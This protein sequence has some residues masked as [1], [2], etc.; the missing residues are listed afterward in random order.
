V[1]YVE[2]LPR[3]LE[4]INRPTSGD[5]GSRER[6]VAEMR[7]AG[8]D[9]VLPLLTEQLKAANPETR[10]DAITALGF[11]DAHRAVE[12]IVAMLDDPDTTVRWHAC[13]C[14]HDFGDERA[15]PALCEVLR[16]DPDPQVRGTAAYALGGIGSPAAIPGLLAALGF[17]NEYDI[18]GH[19]PNS[20]AAT[21]LDEILG[22]RETRTHLGGGLCRMAAGE[23]DLDRLR[24]LAEELFQEWS[25][26]R[27]YRLPGK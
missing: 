21:A 3:L 7:A 8:V 9:K 11:L 4:G 24:Q 23:P 16:R 2:Q 25:V 27:G 13:G 20:C 18:H 17:D 5:D 22:T 6:A 19:S 15:V 10:C 12:P 26:R 14:L 1:T